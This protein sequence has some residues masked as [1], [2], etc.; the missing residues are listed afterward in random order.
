MPASRADLASFAEALAARLPGDWHSTYRQHEAYS[1][2]FPLDDEVWD[3]GHVHWAVGGFVLGH[4]AQLAGPDGQ[5]LCVIDRPLHPDQFLVVPLSPDEGLKSHHFHGVDEPNGIKVSNDPLRAAVAVSRRVLPR[6]QHALAA[7]HHNAQAQPE[8]PLR[9]APPEVDQVLTLTRYAD[10]A[11]G[12]PYAMVPAE[13][14]STLYAHGFQYHP[15][16]GAF[17]LPA[18]YGHIAQARRV[19]SVVQQLAA[20]GIGVNL[21]HNPPPTAVP[22]ALHTRA[23]LPG[24]TPVAHH[25]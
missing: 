3:N 21:R 10:G 6:Y 13:A 11:F 25:R 5:R 4:D 24:S 16:Q 12:T 14:R 7:V 19:L 17:L 20:H 23:P 22:P 9:P 2:Q 18:A 15:H 8:P 1:D